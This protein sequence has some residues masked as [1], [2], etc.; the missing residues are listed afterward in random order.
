MMINASSKRSKRCSQARPH[1]RDGSSHVAGAEAQNQSAIAHLIE[2]VCHFGQQ[3]WKAEVV[4]DHKRPE[5]D[6]AGRGGEGARSDQHS[7]TSPTFA[8]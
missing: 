5:S 7:Q 2:R 3:G 1:A 6:A 4:T 8:G